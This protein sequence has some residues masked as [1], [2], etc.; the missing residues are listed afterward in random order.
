ME[1][2]TPPS[3]LSVHSSSSLLREPYHQRP[4]NQSAESHASS[5]Q[6]NGSLSLFAVNSSPVA[7]TA[8][9]PAASQHDDTFTPDF[10]VSAWSSITDIPFPSTLAPQ[11][12]YPQVAD[13]D[14]DHSPSPSSVSDASTQIAS[15]GGVE[16]TEQP[17]LH[18]TRPS[19]A[20]I[21]FRNDYVAKHSSPRKKQAGNPSKAAA[22][23]WHNELTDA[24]KRA[25]TLRAELIKEEHLRRNPGYKYRPQTLHKKKEAVASNRVKSK[26][27]PTSSQALGRTTS[28]PSVSKT[29]ERDEPRKPYD[30]MQSSPSQDQMLHGS[31]DRTMANHRSPSNLQSHP[32]S[33]RKHSSLA[34]TL[35]QVSSIPSPHGHTNDRAPSMAIRM[36]ATESSLRSQYGTFKP[37]P[38]LSAAASCVLQPSSTNSMSW[39][40]AASYHYQHQN[41]T[42]LPYSHT[43]PTEMSKT[44]AHNYPYSPDTTTRWLPSNNDAA[45]MFRHPVPSSQQWS[46]EPPAPTHLSWGQDVVSHSQP[47][48]DHTATVAGPLLATFPHDYVHPD[49]YS[50]YSGGGGVPASAVLKAPHSSA[51]GARSS[52]SSSSSTIVAQPPQPLPRAPAIAADSSHRAELASSPGTATWWGNTGSSHLQALS[53]VAGGQGQG[54]GVGPW[55]SGERQ[56]GDTPGFVPMGAEHGEKSPGIACPASR[57]SLTGSSWDTSSQQAGLE[58]AYEA[59]MEDLDANPSLN[60]SMA[61]SMRPSNLQQPVM[62][63]MSTFLSFAPS[64]II[65]AG[66]EPSHEDTMFLDI[67]VSSSSTSTAGSSTDG[68]HGFHP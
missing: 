11:E 44:M 46:M 8:V 27:V 15:S 32:Q 1:N 47:E 67:S 63:P 16:G 38:M 43:N 6:L 9:Q 3:R 66:R 20:W 10:H 53:L 57:R 41:N 62:S 22:W 35:Q 31:V 37:D 5:P 13:H 28:M 65:D 39:S 7:S 33:H 23:A 4:R 30:N 12:Y 52:K 45:A 40:P 34:P 64:L 24:D 36:K 60:N 19:N 17:A 42:T 49:G 51:L 48:Q 59:L 14:L 54:H 2:D 25:W 56:D 18:V 29:G 61:P 26:G 55:G 68:L 58:S 21:L 50:V